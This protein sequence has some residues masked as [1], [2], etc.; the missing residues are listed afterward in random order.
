MD[1]LE[2]PI[3]AF[4]EIVLRVKNLQ[5]MQEFYE[6]VIGLELLQRFEEEAVF[7]KVAPGYAGHIQVL[8]LLVEST[9]PDHRSLK[10]TGLDPERTT[11]HHFAFAIGLAQGF[12]TGKYP[13]KIKRSSSPPLLNFVNQII[14]RII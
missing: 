11:I 12:P 14:I 2:R 9:P 10:F 8:G 5:T 1:K 4:G 7:F 6:N 3:K 13:S